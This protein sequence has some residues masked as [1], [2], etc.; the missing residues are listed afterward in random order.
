MRAPTSINLQ[1]SK[2]VVICRDADSARKGFGI[3]EGESGA[4]YTRTGHRFFDSAMESRFLERVHPPLDAAGI[5][6]SLKTDW[7]VSTAN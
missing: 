6:E 3:M 5:W 7:V 4:C 1:H 2:D